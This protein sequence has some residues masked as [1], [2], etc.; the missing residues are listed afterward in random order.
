MINR[1]LLC[2]LMWDASGA[3]GRVAVSVPLY[4]L[5]RSTTKVNINLQRE[6]CFNAK[7]PV[8]RAFNEL[9]RMCVCVE[10]Y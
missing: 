1:E 8:F 9:A 7:H 2:Y 4:S 10:G 5:T 3:F 6:K